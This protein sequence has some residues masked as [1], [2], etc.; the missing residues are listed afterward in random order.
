MWFLLP[1]IIGVVVAV[2]RSR[3]SPSRALPPAPPPSM[4]GPVVVL[5]EFARVGRTP[6]PQLIMC[7]LAEAE[8]CGRQDIAIEI[9]RIYIAPVVE[10]HDLANARDANPEPGQPQ[11]AGRSQSDDIAEQLT[12]Y[13][14]H[15]GVGIVSDPTGVE[16]LEVRWLRG[17]E[18]P[19]FSAPV[20]GRAVRVV[21]VDELATPQTAPQ[22]QPQAAPQ[23]GP[24]DVR[25]L[26]DDE[27]QWMLDHDPAGFQAAMSRGYVD[28][29]ILPE[30]P[31]VSEQAQQHD[32]PETAP[33]VIGVAVGAWSEF[34]DRLE[35]E[36]PQYASSRHVGR[37]RQRRERLA[38]LGIDPAAIVGDPHAQRAALE[39][40]IANAYQALASEG[41]IAR[42]V[43][44]SIP[45]PG[46]DGLHRV[47]LSGVLGVVQAAGLDGAIKWLEHPG[48]RKKFQHTTNAFRATN[49]C[50]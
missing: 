18:A 7:A 19:V 45:L 24:R 37:Y 21:I 6:P 35:R 44:R 10:A 33:P 47:T 30:R 40:D 27:L 38:E 9:V 1:L 32:V 25:A 4:P 5:G 13:P 22:A 26:S 36:P 29:S 41:D 2:N 14:G 49:G 3:T 48:D 23:N 39:A 46:E 42:H 50:F 34:C 11:G 20:D 43:G 28:G 15:A 12:R 31:V 17:Y 16:V 8:M